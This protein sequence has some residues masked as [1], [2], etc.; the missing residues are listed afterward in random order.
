M[1]Q[2][3]TYANAD[4]ILGISAMKQEEVYVEE[5]DLTVL[6]RELS[7]YERNQIQAEMMKKGDGIVMDREIEGQLVAMRIPLDQDARLVAT[8]AIDA[9]GRP[10]FADP[11]TGEVSE[12]A[13]V[14][15]GEKSGN[16]IQKIAAVVRRISG[17]TKEAEEE[18]GKDSASTETSD[19]SSD[20]P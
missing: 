18:A 20:S 6:V 9:D 11:A 14:R 2:N 15:L 7:Q 10:L 17:M 4:Q 19:S 12:E 16:A 5:W 3:G 8:A 1:Q 13:I